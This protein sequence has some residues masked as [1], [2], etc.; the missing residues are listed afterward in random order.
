[1]S[2]PGDDPDRTASGAAHRPRLRDPSLSWIW[3]AI[4]VALVPVLHFLLPEHLF[5][6]EHPVLS[7][8]AFSVALAVIATL[9]LLQV[10]DIQLGRVRSM[11]RPGIVIVALMSLTLL[12]F[13]TAYSAMAREPGQFDGLRTRLDALYFTLVTLATVGYG[14][15]TASGQAAR[16]VTMLQI[17]YDLVILTAAATALS[18]YLRSQLRSRAGRDGTDPDPEE[19]GPDTD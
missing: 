7:W 6:P 16:L 17:V 14:D 3:P 8:T 10:R 15:V 18:H 9:L 13:S 11:K 12:T 5:G 4:S 1:M 2:E 19:S